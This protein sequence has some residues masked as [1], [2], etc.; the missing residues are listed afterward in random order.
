MNISARLVKSDY[1]PET[2]ITEEFW[3]EETPGNQKNKI[4]IRR[5]QD[6]EGLLADNKAQYN[7]HGKGAGNYSG[8]DGLH[9]VATIPLVLLEHWKNV[10]GFDWHNSTDKDRRAKLNDPD[11]KKLLVRP[12]RL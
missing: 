8:S 10:D 12:G 7:E 5:L 2:G 3:Y 1:D 9:K 11:F 6:V 4:H